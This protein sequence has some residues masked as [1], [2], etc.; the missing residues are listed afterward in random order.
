MIEIES[1]EELDRAAE[2]AE[3]AGGS[4]S[5]WQ[6]QGLD[7]TGREDV[8]LRL[9]PRGALFLGCT[10]SEAAAD[11]LRTGGALV[12]PTVPD[13]PF[14]PWRASLYTPAELYD[15]LADGYDRTTDAKVYAWTRTSRP[16]AP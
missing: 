2:R 15:G 10:M 6:V 8:L 4:M 13:V 14:D 16:P 1:L 7:L 5:D 3:A 9:D 11:R 12:F